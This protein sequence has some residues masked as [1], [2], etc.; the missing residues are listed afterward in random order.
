M[1]VKVMIGILGALGFIASISG[2]MIYLN[3]SYAP[4]P[5]FER[6]QTQFISYV[7]NQRLDTLERRLDDYRRNGTCQREPQVCR[8][9]QVDIRRIKRRLGVQ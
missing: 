1:V 5:E 7:D 4:R 9:L 2:G 8:E 3:E 6:L